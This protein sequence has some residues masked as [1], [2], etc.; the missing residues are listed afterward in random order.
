MSKK[1]VQLYIYGTD[2]MYK[3]EWGHPKMS[4][5][6]FFLIRHFSPKC[7]LPVI[8]S[9]SQKSTGN[10]LMLLKLFHELLY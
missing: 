10:F 3:D 9:Y 8:K 7:L 4:T 2:N 1:N 6:K 5:G